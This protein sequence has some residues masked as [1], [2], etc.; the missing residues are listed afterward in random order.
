MTYEEFAPLFTMLVSEKKTQD[1]F[2]RCLPESIAEAFFEN[3]Y[4]GSLERQISS[5]MELM[6]PDKDL[7]EAVYHMMY[8]YNVWD[9]DEI[10]PDTLEEKLAYFKE[11]YFS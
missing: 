7:L 8:E 9:S 10:N 1:D 6:F 3:E 2:I 11:N 5:L 4:V